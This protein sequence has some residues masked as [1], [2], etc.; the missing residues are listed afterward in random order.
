MLLS[1][2][3]ITLIWGDFSPDFTVYPGIL[4]DCVQARKS[5][6]SLGMRRIGS[7]LA[8]CTGY[9]YAPLWTHT[10]GVHTT[11]NFSIL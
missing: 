6:K 10:F 8:V 2:D 3:K 9:F 7:S 5:A 11:T 4:T 1:F